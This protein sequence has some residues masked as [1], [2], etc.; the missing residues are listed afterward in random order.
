MQRLNSTTSTDNCNHT[1]GGDNNGNGAAASNR[2][3]R[4]CGADEVSGDGQLCRFE[5]EKN[6]ILIANQ[7]GTIHA[8]DLVCT[9]ADADLST[10]F[11]GPDGIRCPLHLSV[12]DLKSG[13]PHNPPAERSLRVYNIKIDDGHVYVE[14]Q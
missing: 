1:R 4:V 8:T 3:I 2:W 14:V 7:N 5:D 6:S 9:H 13:N 12:F 10:G 11:L